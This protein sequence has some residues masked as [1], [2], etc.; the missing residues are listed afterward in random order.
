MAPS[1]FGDEEVASRRGGIL[2]RDTSG[3]REGEGAGV[4]RSI[5]GGFDVIVFRRK[6]GVCAAN[7]DGLAVLLG[8]RE[9]EPV[10]A[11]D[12]RAQGTRHEVSRHLEGLVEHGLKTAR[13]DAQV[14]LGWVATGQ[15]A[16]TVGC[17]DGELDL[18]DAKRQHDGF[19]V[20]DDFVGGLNA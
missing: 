8:G 13:D 4:S 3:Q 17:S 14:D 9:G 10:G 1:V 11:D 15:V 18:R 6:A 20:A 16:V 5:D 12:G 7:F 2:N 19:V